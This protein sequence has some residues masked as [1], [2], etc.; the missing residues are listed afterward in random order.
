[1]GNIGIL[2]SGGDDISFNKSAKCTLIMSKIIS[3]KIIVDRG[4]KSNG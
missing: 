4:E 1:M 3:M 2:C